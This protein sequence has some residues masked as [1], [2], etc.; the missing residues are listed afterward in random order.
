M[1]LGK[2]SFE[3]L[4]EFG[5]SVTQAKRVIAY[6]ERLGGFG[7]VDELDQVPGFSKTFLNEIKSRLR[8]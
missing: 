6:R 2:A 5:M 8:P 3:E 1:S 7:S 4:R